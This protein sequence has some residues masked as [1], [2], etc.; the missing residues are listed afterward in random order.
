MVIPGGI[1]HAGV[2]TV[3]PEMVGPKWRGLFRIQDGVDITVDQHRPDDGAG[4]RVRMLAE[5][6]RLADEVV[7]LGRCQP[8]MRHAVAGRR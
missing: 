7:I 2:K 4:Q 3:G 1:V 5:A 6:C 8:G